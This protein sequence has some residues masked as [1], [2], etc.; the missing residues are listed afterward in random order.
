[1]FR[2]SS[3]R[4]FLSE[5]ISSTR[6]IR[7][8]SP[9][10]D[11]CIFCLKPSQSSPFG[12]SAGAPDGAATFAFVKIPP[13][14]AFAAA[15]RSEAKFSL[16]VISPSGEAN[17][18]ITT[19]LISSESTRAASSAKFCSATQSASFNS[20]GRTTDL[21]TS[22]LIT[23]SRVRVVVRTNASVLGMKR[24]SSC[25]SKGVVITPVPIGIGAKVSDF[26][27]FE[28]VTRTASSATSSIAGSKGMDAV[29]E[30]ALPVSNGTTWSFPATDSP[31]Y[32]AVVKSAVPPFQVRTGVAC[33]L[34]FFAKY[35]SGNLPVTSSSTCPPRKISGSGDALRPRASISF[36]MLP[37]PVQ[38][39]ANIATAAAPTYGRKTE[40][41]T[42]IRRKNCGAKL[43]N[44]LNRR[45]H[46]APK[47]QK[48]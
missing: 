32:R 15:A 40:V 39:A 35:F 37:S 14:T 4:L 12:C 26:D 28:P 19:D 7:F 16:M 33:R 45:A 21:L 24:S 27:P 17:A 9:M 41:N 25:S 43:H 3:S 2:I 10:L 34:T 20:A 29:Y 44:R 6:K 13:N 48:G 22:K 47:P 18:S 1:M 38:P 11:A 5:Y 36:S 31:W 46:L 23:A 30:M 8:L 42:F